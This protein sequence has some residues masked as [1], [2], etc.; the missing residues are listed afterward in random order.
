MLSK[1]C[2]KT[3]QAKNTLQRRKLPDAS[4]EKGHKNGKFVKKNVTC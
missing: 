3:I 2:A 4:E 1:S